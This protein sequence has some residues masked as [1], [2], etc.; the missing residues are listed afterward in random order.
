MMSTVHKSY[1]FDNNTFLLTGATGFLGKNV[2]K[3]LTSQLKPKP[4]IISIQRPNSTTGLEGSY[5]TKP[6]DLRRVRLCSEELLEADYVL[7]MASLRNHHA[8][9]R[10]LW[11]HNV[12]PIESTIHILNHSNR[13]KRFIYISSISAVDHAEY[14]YRPIDDESEPMP[15]IEY[16]RSKL[17]AERRLL[18]SGLPVCI[19]RLPFLYGPYFRKDS[20]TYFCRRA[21]YHPIL[22]RIRYTGNLSLLFTGDV[23]PLLIELLSEKNRKIADSSPYVVS[24]GNVYEFIISYH[25]WRGYTIEKDQIFEF[26]VSSGRSPTE[27]SGIQKWII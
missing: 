2:I 5:F 23:G 20:F 14:P 9:P 8:N 19:L 16:G 6:C 7:W 10:A 4:R 24:D 3:Y 12:A 15:K 13:L 17:E 26:Q 11:D 22:G 1:D 27:Y 21:A 25:W 18:M